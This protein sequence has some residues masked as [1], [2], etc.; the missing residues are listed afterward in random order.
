MRREV[1]GATL[2]RRPSLDAYLF[3]PALVFRDMFGLLIVL[4]VPER[5]R[6]RSRTTRRFSKRGTERP[7]RIGV[8]IVGRR[9]RGAREIG[10]ASG[11]GENPFKS[12]S[13]CFPARLGWKKA[14][15]RHLA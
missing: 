4:D 1:G 9:I 13:K 8:L 10:R 15:K 6:G 2:P 11:S 12:R 7:E 5:M 3:I 14:R